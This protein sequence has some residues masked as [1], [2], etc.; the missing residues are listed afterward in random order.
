[1]KMALGMA[2]TGL[3]LALGGAMAP[4]RADNDNAKWNVGIRPDQSSHLEQNWADIQKK[5]A[6]WRRLQQRQ[7]RIKRRH[8]Q[9]RHPVPVNRL[10][11]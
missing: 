8:A 4:L 3:V 7:A 9:V 11:R 5:L 6:T 10:G 1:M 2:V